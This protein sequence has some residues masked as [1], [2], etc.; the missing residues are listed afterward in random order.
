MGVILEYLSDYQPLKRI[1][2]HGVFYVFC[3]DEIKQKYQSSRCIK[4]P[5]LTVSRLPFKSMLP[6][7]VTWKF[8]FVILIFILTDN[9]TASGQALG[10][11]RSPVQWIPGSLSPEV[12]QPGRVANH[13]PPS[14]AEVKKAWGYTPLPQYAFM[15]W[16]SV[17]KSAGQLYLYLYGLDDQS[18]NP[19]RG[20]DFSFR[21]YV[22][23]DLGPTQPP[24]QRVQGI[25]R[26]DKDAGA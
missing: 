7:I 22:D 10:P 13:S 23:T 1:L 9:T 18:S 20:R 5:D 8:I 12:G 19:G 17:K 15:V 24:I 21:R 3:R 2:L 4:T 6:I 16:C 11:S 25:F 26:G 14:S